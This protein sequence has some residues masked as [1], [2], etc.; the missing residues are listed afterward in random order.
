MPARRV[1]DSDD[2]ASLSHNSIR[3]IHEQNPGILWIGTAGG[4]LNKFDLSTH[5]FVRFTTEDGLP[6]NVIYGI[7]VDAAGHL[8][9][10]TN[11][12]LAKFDPRTETFHHYDVHDGLQ[13]NE[14]NVGAHF[15]S[16][17]GEMFFG[18]W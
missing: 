2:P 1:Q 13:N 5:K 6:N 16:E 11:G 10:S 12:G 14:F 7:E 4:G 9:L 3:A 8:W 17:G 15:K 18:G